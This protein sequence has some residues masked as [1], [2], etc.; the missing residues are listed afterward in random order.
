MSDLFRDQ[1]LK[2]GLATKKQAKAVLHEENKS[3]RK[4]RKKQGGDVA[5]TPEQAAARAALE[6][7]RERDRA[8]NQAREAE[9]EARARD[10][11]VDNLIA[12]HRLRDTDGDVPY[13]FPDGDTIKTIRVSAATQRD[14]AAGAIG[15]VD[16]A[17]GYCLVRRDTALAIEERV[18]DRL[19]LLFE[20]ET[21]EDDDPYSEYEV[22][23][24]L[25]W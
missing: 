3:R 11:E 17:P 7:K 1:L 16:G 10:A 20:P 19:V 22:P 24:D 12:D 25:M 18:P 13:K 8:L 5:E 2:A 6:E 23:D 15:I 14:L 4:R 21:V 9:R